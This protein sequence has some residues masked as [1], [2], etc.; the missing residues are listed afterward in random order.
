V[1]TERLAGRPTGPSAR[2]QTSERRADFGSTVALTITL[3]LAAFLALMA[4]VVLLAHPQLA[5]LGPSPGLV[6]KQN[7]TGKSLL[8][9]VTFAVILPAAVILVPRLADAIAAGHNGAA[10]G[11]LSALIVSSLALLLIAIRL[12]HRLPWGDGLKVVLVGALIWSAVAGGMLARSAAGGAWPALVRLAA[13]RRTAWLCA[14]VLVFAALLCVTARGSLHAVPLLLGALL[15]VALLLVASRLRTPGG[16]RGGRVIDVVMI[17]ALALAIPNVIVYTS[18]GALPNIYFPPGVIADQQNYLLGSAN[19]LLGG[20][21]LLVNVP[22]SQYGVGL[23]YFLD[24]WFHLVHIGYG[25]TGLLDGILTALSFILAYVVLRIARTGPLLAV[26]ALA[27]AVLVLVYGRQYNV[28]ALPETG[29]LRFGLPLL[30]VAST[31]CAVRWPQRRAF[32]PVTFIALGVS[33]VWALEAFLYS[34]VVFAAAAAIRAWLLAPGQRR[35][36]LLRQAAFAVGACVTAHVVLALITLA[37]TGELPDWGQY[38]TYIHSFLLGGQAGAITYGFPRWPPG[39]AVDAAAFASAA[40]LVLLARRVPSVA[41]REPVVTV[42]LAGSTAYTIAL[43]SYTD[44]RSLTYLLVYV[45]LPLLMAAVLW[46][47]L[48]LRAPESGIAVRRAAG[49]FSVAVTVLMISAAWPLIGG[50]F[51]QSALAHAYPGGGLSADLH[52][53]AHPPAI[54]PRAP[55]AVRLLNRYVPG[56]RALIVLPVDPDLG[57]E[58]LMRGDRTNSMFIGDP[59]DDSLVPSLWMQKLTT[60]VARLRA[61]QRLLIDEGTLRVLAGLRAHPN[62]DPAAHPI[63]GGDQELEWLARQIDRR[64]AIKPIAR[65]RDGL[66]VAELQPR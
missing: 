40:A 22:V 61:G 60:E 16:R 37:I 30:I 13:L 44:N 65:A 6:N 66:I 23:I 28:G 11:T 52:R 32:A 54:D 43:M 20:G 24:G 2:A 51:S 7:Q 5:G 42:A 1:A 49:A 25:T 35:P 50:N 38:L 34:I 57:V 62:I 56:H 53:L 21:A 39:L 64:F 41:R 31:T 14:A 59:V 27:V 17:V 47:V 18:T 33:A 45:S 63:D 3:A 10:L 58:I 26:A 4:I 55:V 19:Q 12:S 15:G 29:P 48:I 8:Y 46:L 9:L 36:W